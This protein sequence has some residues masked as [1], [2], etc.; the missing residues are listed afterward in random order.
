MLILRF[1]T[2]AFKKFSKKP[3]LIEVDKTERDFGEW[4]VNTVDSANRGNIFM[5][6]MHTE[7][8]YTMLVPI[9]KNMD[10]SDFLH[11]VFANMLLRILRLEVPRKNA[12][13]IMDSYDGHTLYAKT[14]SRSLVASLST[15]IKDIDVIMEWPERFV[16]NDNTLDI[17]RM[18]YQINDTPRGLDGNTIWPIDEFYRCIRRFC[19]ELSVRGSL[20][21]K[22]SSMSNP[23]KL[24]ELFDH[25]V[26]EHL[27]LKVKASI[28]EAD[29]LFDIEETR[30]L[31]KA[32]DNSRANMSEKLYT[33]LI[34]ML[35][36]QIQKREKQ[37]HP[38]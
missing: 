32:V 16:K 5:L 10:L 38:E 19:P 37:A 11:T 25:Q 3:Q 18:E 7:S 35:N 30:A 13:Q 6:V 15:V 24:M 22:Y 27:A 12:Q 21:L 28:L 36:F 4:Y 34:R 26:S 20:P 17:T 31:L 8:L 14:N 29:V 1:T 9:E 33:D 23:E 2:K